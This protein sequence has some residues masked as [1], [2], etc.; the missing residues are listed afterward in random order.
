MDSL[1]GISFQTNGDYYRSYSINFVKPGLGGKK[2]TRFSFSFILHSLLTEG[3]V[4]VQ[5]AILLY[6]TQE[7]LLHVHR[8]VYWLGRR[9]KW[10]DDYITLMNELTYQRYRAQNWSGS[11]YYSLAFKTGTSTASLLLPPLTQI[12]RMCSCIHSGSAFTLSLTLTPPGPSST[13]RTTQD[14]YR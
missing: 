11:S 8:L 4:P 6:G 5:Q 9:L 10:P 12:P 1:L 3:R 14:G 2:P 7:Q 13:V